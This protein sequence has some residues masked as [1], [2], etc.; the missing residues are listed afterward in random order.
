MTR[1]RL[2]IRRLG[3]R[4]EGVADG[5]NGPVYVP[6]GL[7]GETV[8][9]DPDAA[10]LAP[11]ILHARPD[12]VD[13]V[14]PYYGTC[15]GCAV[16]TLPHPLYAEWKRG[17]VADVL[18]K[19]GIEVEVGQL[20]DAHGTGRRR[21]TFHARA[22]ASPNVLRQGPPRV[23][24]MRAR[25]HEIIDI[26]T[27]PILAP[28]LGRA[29]PAAHAIATAV[30][31]LGKPMD[32]VVTAS[33]AG[34]DIDLRG[35]GPIPPER[36]TKLADLAAA[37]DLARLA[38]HGDVILERRPP[39]LP[40]GAARPVLPPGGFLQATAAGEAAMAGLV[41]EAVASARKVA[42]LFCGLGTFA[43]R[44]AETATVA[45]F[46]LEGPSLAA[47]ARAAR[48]ATH[49]RPVT[50]TA[51]DLVRR[52][53]TAAELAGFDAVVFDPPRAGALAQA[54]A[55]AA[56]VVPTVVA[57]S[58]NPATFARDAAALLQGGYRLERVTPIDQFLFSPHVEI[59]GVFRRPKA[60]ARSK[61]GLFG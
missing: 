53:L 50:A 30:Q 21:A 39:T 35:L 55:L 61:R 15:G 25:S 45:A 14:C 46:D 41:V 36:R 44:L 23:G 9:A 6:Y 51:R 4:G 16:Q 27:C 48:A 26:A 54:E 18:R 2:E 47:L 57:V 43:L 60:R 19:A 56:S 59:V 1:Q 58:C 31:D 32:I 29:L 40:I 52:P 11:E 22:S 37:L 12:R 28:E 42:D 7:P 24:F 34:L 8:L 10:G 3:Q 5:A 17:L 38:N 33:L 49:L 13:P 20:L